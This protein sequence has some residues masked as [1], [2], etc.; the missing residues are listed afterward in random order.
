MSPF[1]PGRLLLVGRLRGPSRQAPGQSR[2]LLCVFQNQLL[3]KGMVILRDKIRFYEG[4]WQPCTRDRVPR[5]LLAG[6]AAG[7]R[8]WCPRMVALQA[9]LLE[10][11]PCQPC[12]APRALGGP[13]RGRNDA[14]GRQGWDPAP[15]GA[16]VGESVCP[17]VCWGPGGPETSGRCPAST[18]RPRAFWLQGTPSGSPRTGGG[19][20]RAEAALTLHREAAEAGS[21]HLDGSSG[22]TGFGA[23][24]GVLGKS[25]L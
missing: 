21:C 2:H 8:G 6:V 14:P 16:L 22:L 4:E 19:G 15:G 18:R 7:H 10:P 9:C 1:P 11:W 24:Q 12:W 25:V 23:A 5:H 3:T 20:A 13:R 17:P